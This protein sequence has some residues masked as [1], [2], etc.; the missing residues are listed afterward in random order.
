MQ[1]EEQCSARK[2]FVRCKGAAL[3]LCRKESEL[4]QQNWGLLLFVRQNKLTGEGACVICTSAFSGSWRDFKC[5][6]IHIEKCGSGMLPLLWFL[7]LSTHITA[8]VSFL[9]LLSFLGKIPSRDTSVQIRYDIWNSIVYGINY[10]YYSVPSE[11]PPLLSFVQLTDRTFII[12][13]GVSL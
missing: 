3:C 5:F 1:N 11:C 4:L 13:K 2:L 10:W 9:L 7:P 8:A 12:A 6:Q